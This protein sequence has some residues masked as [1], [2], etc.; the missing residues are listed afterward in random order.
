ML[1]GAAAQ[2]IMFS[3]SSNPVEL[4]DNVDLEYAK[5][6]RVSPPSLP[7]FP[8]DSSSSS[9]WPPPLAYP[10]ADPVTR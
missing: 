7:K 4:T 3:T 9:L 5:N 10:F 6:N 2:N 8:F 1:G